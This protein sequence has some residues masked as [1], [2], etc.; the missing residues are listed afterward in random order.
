M[1]NDLQQ[2]ADKFLNLTSRL[3]RLGP[4]TPPPAEAQISL[5]LI[6]VVDYVAATPGCG[7]QEVAQGLDL[8]TPSVSINVS[9]LEKADFIE[10][11]P[12]PDDGRAV[13][14]FLSPE[15]EELH[16]RTH[17][18][19]RQKFERL[20]IGLTP[21]ERDTLLDLLERAIST[22]ENQGEKND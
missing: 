3:R 8:S 18:F 4:G 11:Q 5:S 12:D 19:R 10:R 15:G 20:L 17:S 6:T 1:A 16:Q 9:R 14:L 2:A 22:A 7:I 13:Q 21:E